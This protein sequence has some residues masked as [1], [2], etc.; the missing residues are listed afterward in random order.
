MDGL[1]RKDY[2]PAVESTCVPAIVSP[3]PHVQPNALLGAIFAA[4]SVRSVMLALERGPALKR[5]LH[6]DNAQ[7]E[8]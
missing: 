1:P 2:K 7:V 3:F 5:K 8:H 6:Y 4:D